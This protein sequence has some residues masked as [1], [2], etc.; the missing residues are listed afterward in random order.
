MEVSVVVQ[1]II[2]KLLPSSVNET[3]NGLEDSI[4]F[5]YFY[6]LVQLKSTESNVNVPG[7]KEMQQNVIYYYY[8][9]FFK[10][11]NYKY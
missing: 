11:N 4:G 10:A 9:Y 1:E 7:V 6:I 8:Y 2:N 3:T 5:L